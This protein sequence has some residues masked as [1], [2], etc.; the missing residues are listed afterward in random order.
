MEREE[1]ERRVLLFNMYIIVFGKGIIMA[2]HN[3]TPQN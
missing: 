3:T 2:V 1:K